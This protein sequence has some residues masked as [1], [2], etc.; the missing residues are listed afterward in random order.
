MARS[1]VTISDSL[2]PALNLVYTLFDIM[3]SRATL[4]SSDIEG[5]L[6][7][8][9]TVAVSSMPSLP[10]LVRRFLPPPLTPFDDDDDDDDEEEEEEEE[11]ED[12]DV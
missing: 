3:N 6:A 7:A 8:I 2:V 10:L 5:K 1:R 11:E 4:S 12:G 9:P